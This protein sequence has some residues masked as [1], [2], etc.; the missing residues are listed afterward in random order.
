MV[1]DLAVA[2]A[3]AGPG[4]V[5]QVRCVGHAF[6]AAG[7]HHLGTAGQQHVVGQHRGFHARTAHLVQGGAAGRLV[8]ART[9][10]GL[11]RRGLA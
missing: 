9:Q 4:P 6:H 5:Q 3:Q 7:D 11:S 10:G 8:Q 2:H 1:Q